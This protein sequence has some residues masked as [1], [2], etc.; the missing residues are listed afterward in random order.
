MNHLLPRV[1]KKKKILNL[2]KKY[3][4]SCSELSK[5]RI[6]KGGFNERKPRSGAR[7]EL[8]TN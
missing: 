1:F 4:T 8:V 6:V 2:I 5:Q 7:L 3:F